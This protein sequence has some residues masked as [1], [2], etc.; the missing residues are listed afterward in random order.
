MFKLL[1][2]DLQSIFFKIQSL[3]LSA[4][5]LLVGFVY[6]YTPTEIA[7]TVNINGTEIS[8]G[9]SIEISADGSLNII[10]HCENTGRP[11]E[12]TDFHNNAH[13]SIYKYE[14]GEKT[15]LSVSY[16]GVDAEPNPILIK[17]GESF[18]EYFHCV[19]DPDAEPGTY[20]ME[21]QVFG[22][23]QIYENVLTVV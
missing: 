19:L 15:Y 20:T 7:Y 11:F 8:A 16:I 1:Y 2:Y 12:G 6:G 13:V 21:V 10:C 9:D 18:T 17:S 14:N 22:H 4:V 5:L 23:K 3:L